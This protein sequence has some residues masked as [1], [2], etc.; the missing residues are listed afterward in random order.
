VFSTLAPVWTMALLS[1]VMATKHY[2]ADFL[3]QTNWIARGKDC[4]DKWFLPLLTHVMGHAVLTLLVALVVA[5]R[6]WWLALVDFAIHFLVDR[7]KG[8]V[9]LANSV[10]PKDRA[11]WWVLGFDQYLHQVTN[12]MIAAALLSL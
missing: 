3:L 1:I 5:P 4:P 12:I 2:I 11:F 8:L 7:G 9:C 6:L 10:G